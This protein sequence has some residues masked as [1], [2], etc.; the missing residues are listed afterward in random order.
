M[1]FASLYRIVTIVRLTETEDI[2]WAKSD[3]FIWSSVEPS[4]GIIS[5][6]LPTLR[7]PLMHFLRTV[8]GYEDPF[9]SSGGSHQPAHQL[10]EIETISKKKSR[11]PVKDILEETQKSQI[12]QTTLV[13]D[14]KD[15]PILEQRPSFS[16]FGSNRNEKVVLRPDEDEVCLTTVIEGKDNQSNNQAEEKSLSESGEGIKVHKDFTWWESGT[17][18][19]G[20]AD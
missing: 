8:F 3:V 4:V 5:G 14:E 10:P 1:C 12:T 13:G 9:G 16:R 20:Q 7:A 2:S 6:C 19:P 11:K 18:K 17:Q 15:D